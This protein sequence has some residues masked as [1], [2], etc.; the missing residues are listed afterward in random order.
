MAS[1]VEEEIAV[2]IGDGFCCLDR[3][4]NRGSMCIRDCRR[5]LRMLDVGLEEQH[6][7]SGRKS[8]RSNRG[9]FRP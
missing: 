3:R 2:K 1:V 9:L 8:Q 6:S 7:T 5:G 4:G